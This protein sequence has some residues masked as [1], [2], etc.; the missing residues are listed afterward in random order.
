MPEP[1][2]DQTPR[3][4]ELD[5]IA[6]EIGIP[7]CPD[8]LIRFSAEMHQEEPDIHKLANLIGTDIALSASLLKLVNSPF[9]GLKTKATNIHQAL[10]IIGL[11]AG[12]NLITGL[13]L[14]EAFPS[15]GSRLMRQFWEKSAAVTTVAMSL[16]S[17]ITGIDPDEA[18]AY[19]LFRDCGIPVMIKKFPDYGEIMSNLEEK[20]GARVTAHEQSKYHYSHARVGYA[21]ASGWLL[22]EPFCRAILHHHDFE[23]V[24]TKRR[25]VEPVNYKLIAFG[26]LMEQI[27]ALRSTGNLCPDWES[28]EQLVLDTFEIAPDE[29]IALALEPE[30]QSD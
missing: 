29:I 25:E 6:R 22:P 14:R 18:H 4:E 19:A 10:S 26:L 11:R 23:K 15:D 3:T 8:V 9:Y 5:R 7:P 2:P 13:I 20:P 24:I 17:K 28:G 30:L 27:A 12:A 16:A 1:T 21:L